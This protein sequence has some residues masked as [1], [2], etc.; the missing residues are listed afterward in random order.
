MSSSLNLKISP[1]PPSQV[2]QGKTIS[3]TSHLLVGDSSYKPWQAE[4]EISDSAS[5]QQVVWLVYCTYSD[6]LKDNGGSYI[7]NSLC[8]PITFSK[9]PSQFY[10]QYIKIHWFLEFNTQV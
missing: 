5:L 7:V 9:Y 4:E 3:D 10:L 2:T 6:I 1:P 8:L